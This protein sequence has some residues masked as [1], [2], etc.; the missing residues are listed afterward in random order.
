MG[1]EKTRKDIVI[2]EAGKYCL[3]LSKLV[4]GGIILAGVMDLGI[5]LVPLICVGLGVVFVFAAA[6]MLGIY[7]SNHKEA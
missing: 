4:F 3:D 2:E 1:N 7:L 6:G 5:E